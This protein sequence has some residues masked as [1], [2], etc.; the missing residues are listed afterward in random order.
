MSAGVDNEMDAQI[1]MYLQN[2]TETEN[3]VCGRFEFP[4]SF[5]GFAGHFPDQ[6]VLPGICKIKAGLILL[7][8]QYG[9]V[10]EIKEIVRA[11]FFSPVSVNQPLDFICKELSAH[12]AD[13][14][15][16]IHITGQEE[17]K[18]AYLKLN[19]ILEKRDQ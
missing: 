8:Q 9:A 2:M 11:K 12:G 15:V 19:V 16:S 4:E 14:V 1:K 18:I 17:K 6:P 3:G 5:I 10:V 7:E 13:R